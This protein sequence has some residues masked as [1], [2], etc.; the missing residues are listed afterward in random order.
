MT[1][2]DRAYY[3]RNKERLLAQNKLRR[4]GE[5]RE[6]VLAKK[7]EYYQRNKERILQ[8]QREQYRSDNG[9]RLARVTRYRAKNADVIRQR[10]AEYRARKSEQI[11]EKKRRDYIANRGEVLARRKANQ[12]IQEYNRR[13]KAENKEKMAA[14]AKAYREENAEA[15]REKRRQNQPMLREYKRFAQNRRKARKTGNGGSHTYEQWQALCREHD[16]CCAYC[17]VRDTLS[18]DHKLPLSRGGS[19]DI[20]NIAPACKP[21]NFSK[22]K[23]TVEE[24]LTW[25]AAIYSHPRRKNKPYVRC[26]PPA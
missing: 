16:G 8:E 9:M 14:R 13:Y 15:I 19:D 7:R 24:F 5:K 26:S 12:A 3:L 21:C 17:G 4:E 2:K 6:E 18:E 20:E 11:A 25:R 23:R 1:D 22:G 10:K